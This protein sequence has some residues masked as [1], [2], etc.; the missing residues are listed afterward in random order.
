MLKSDFMKRLFFFAAVLGCAGCA[1]TAVDNLQVDG[2]IQEI[3][4][5]ESLMNDSIHTD[6]AN[7]L[8]AG[9]KD[10][11]LIIRINYSGGCKDHYFGLYSLSVFDES[12]P[13]QLDMRLSHNGNGDDCDRIMYD[14]LYFDLTSVKN[15]FIINY[16]SS[17]GEVYLN[18]NDPSMVLFYPKPLYKF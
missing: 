9:I 12:F 5:T 13:V 1:D 10:N 18:I 16:R 7:I 14:T 15:L 2:I 4:Y 3:I 17:S 8:S 6:A 11:I